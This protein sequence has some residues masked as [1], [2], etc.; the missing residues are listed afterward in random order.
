MVKVSIV[1]LIFTSKEY[2]DFLY[3]QL[4][5]NT[6]ILKTGEA[7]FY[8]V[9]N[10]KKGE[11]ESVIA[12]LNNMA[13]KYYIYDKE[14]EQKEY[15]NNIG[16]IYNAWNFAAEKAS[17]EI[18]VFVNSDMAFSKDWL[19]NLLK[20][21]NKTKVVSPIL[22]ESGK[23]NSL[24]PHTITKNFGRNHKTFQEE[25][26]KDFAEVL[27]EDTE[28]ILG[29]FMPVAI[30]KENFIKAGGY[31]EG[32]RILPSGL[33]ISGDWIFFYER[34]EKLGIKHTTS[35]DSIVYHIQTGEVDSNK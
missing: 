33:N 12:H 29:A 26:F 35:F 2:A 34:L 8:F 25:K 22:V 10:F 32:N 17:G 13:R 20:R 21:L 1:S 14:P 9:V 5:D 3:Y 15:P 19:E 11:S 16:S 4:M 18:I 28:Q 7:E 30:H 31:P 23:L 24:L 27:K 6:P